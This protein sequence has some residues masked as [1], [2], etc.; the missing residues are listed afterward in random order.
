MRPQQREWTTAGLRNKD[1]TACGFALLD[2]GYPAV[3]QTASPTAPIKQ[4]GFKVSPSPRRKL[5]TAMS[6]REGKKMVLPQVF[7]MA[8]F[9]AFHMAPESLNFMVYA[10]TVVSTNLTKNFI[11]TCQH[12]IATQA[13]FVLTQ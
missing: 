7:P 11:S 8:L 13:T 2:L 10:I 3:E 12:E 5:A 6:L 1:G 4:G 9:Q